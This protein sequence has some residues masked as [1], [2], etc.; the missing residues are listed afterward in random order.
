MEK[1]RERDRLARKAVNVKQMKS[2]QQ[3]ADSTEVVTTKSVKVAKSAKAEG[4]T[5]S[6][7]RSPEPVAKLKKVG[8]AEN[9][10]KR[11]W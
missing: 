8:E 3:K 11:S 9:R 10:G 1:K 7:K 6:E 5:D 4:K 2:E